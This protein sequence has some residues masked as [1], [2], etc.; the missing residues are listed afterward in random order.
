MDNSTLCYIEKDGQYLM[1]HRVK[2]KL[3][4]NE[5]KW[6]GVGGHFEE[7]GLK[8]INP[9]YRGLVTFVSRSGGK[10]Y[11]EQMHLFTC[12]E[13]SG[14]LMSDCDEGVLKWVKKEDVPALPLWEGDRI[15]LKLLGEEK[16]FFLLKLEYSDDTLVNAET[17]V[18]GA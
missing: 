7:T 11:T 18:A 14:E 5:G 17:A 4:I 12:A 1:L 6:I 2:K 16:R 8:L 13:F 10:L 15:F 3:D 9:R